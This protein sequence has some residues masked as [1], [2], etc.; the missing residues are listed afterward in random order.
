M[1]PNNLLYFEANRISW[2]KRA[3]VHKD[4]AFYDLDSFRKGKTSLQPAE[5]EALGDVQGKSLL[6]LQCHFGMDTLS[7]ARMGAK[8]TGI[9]LSDEAIAI[10]KDL[11]DELNLDAEFICCNVYDVPAYTNKQ[12]DIVFTSYGVIGWLPDLDAWAQVIS[13]SLVPGGTF[14]MAEFHPVVW[15]MDENF[16][17][18]KCHYHNHEV[19]EETANTTY[20]DRDT[21]INITDYS[22]NHSLGEVITA[23]LAHGL[24]ITLF[25]EYP[26]SYY[27]C[28]NKTVQGADGYYRIQG[29]E[30]KLPMMYTIKATRK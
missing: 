6:H 9:D 3:M 11:A 18:I 23:L 21:A 12:Y 10:A 14:F 8:V 4:S 7:W 24:E 5:L 16:E 17:Y 20:A 15:M 2:N 22:W 13:A 19:I 27:N 29:L 1:Q 28:F 30:D 25:K 26:Y